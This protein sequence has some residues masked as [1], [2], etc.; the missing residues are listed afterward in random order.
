MAAT[1]PCLKG[2]MKSFT[3]SGVTGTMGYG[4]SHG[5]A[6][7]S[8]NQRYELSSFNKGQR[9]QDR[10]QRQS[11]SRLND[12]GYTANIYSPSHKDS[13]SRTSHGST[14]IIIKKVVEITTAD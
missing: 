3:T 9:T 2:F 13:A 11:H 5:N 4:S 10:S 6:G 1:I 12:I 14:E 8:H 7:G